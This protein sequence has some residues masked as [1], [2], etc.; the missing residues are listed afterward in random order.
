MSGS[1]SSDPVLAATR[2]DVAA[3][4]T[5]L[6]VHSSPDP[7]TPDDAR[8]R[9]GRWRM[10]LIFVLCAAPVV[11]SYFTFYVVRPSG[12]ANYSELVTPPR[13]LPAASELPL[14][15]LQGVSVDPAALKGQ[16]L[17]VV[18]GAAACDK[19]CEDLLVLQRQ[20]RET[21]GKERDRV[22]KVWFV[23]DGAPLRPELADATSAGVPVTILRAPRAALVGWLSP[24][25]GH[26]LE[27][28]MYV[29]DPMGQWMMR[30]PVDPDPAK[31]KR[32]IDRLLRASS[33]WDLP[34]R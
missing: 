34:G 2:A 26:R 16:W 4:A 17:L 31:L 9:R 7:V 11:A 3:D 21:F 15:D 32:D 5:G 13:M 19:Q 20:L 14:T 23:T 12:S 27:Q 18:V 6:T 1:N 24:A 29:V 8:T 33:S 28:H 25:A 22:D 10:L 30:V